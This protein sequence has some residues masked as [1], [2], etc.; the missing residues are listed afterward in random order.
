[1]NRE[2]L[3]SL[4]QTALGGTATRM[5][6]ELALDAV[7]RSLRE[8]LLSD[9]EVRLARFGTFRLRT[10]APRRLLLPGSEREMTLPSR[11]VLSF[12]PSPHAR[13]KQENSHHDTLS[14]SHPACNEGE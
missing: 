2:H 3:L 14:A 13:Q 8:G 1:M 9:G 10:R 7:V 12:S 11:C 6:A 5:A 4:V